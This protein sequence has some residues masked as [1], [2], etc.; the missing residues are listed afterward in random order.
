MALLVGEG[1]C[2]WRTELCL[3]LGGVRLRCGP[4]PDGSATVPP[5]NAPRGDRAIRESRTTSRA[6]WRYWSGLCGRAGRVGTA[7]HTEEDLEEEF[8]YP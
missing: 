7:V 5:R 3:L 6:P 2:G 4:M 8:K 1:R